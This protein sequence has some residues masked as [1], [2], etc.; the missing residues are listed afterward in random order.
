LRK[1]TGAQHAK[2]VLRSR[3]LAGPPQVNDK[4]GFSLG[5]RVLFDRIKFAL[6]FDDHQLEPLAH[7]GIDHHGG[8]AFC[9]GNLEGARR[10]QAWLSQ[11]WSTRSPQPARK[12]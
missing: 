9:A 7:C 6:E 10:R 11:V 2:D 12:S 3:C 1:S 4:C 8:E 5:N